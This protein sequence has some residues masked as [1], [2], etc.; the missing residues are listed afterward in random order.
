[1]PSC[2]CITATPLNNHQELEF[3]ADA[4]VI[5]PRQLSTMLSQLPADLDSESQE[6]RSL[7]RQHQPS[8]LQ[9]V[10]PAPI[11]AP[12]QAQPP[13]AA[14]SPP[15]PAATPS[16]NE[17]AALHNQYASP[18]PQAPPAYPQVPPILS[19]AS[20]LYA[21]TPTDQGDLALQPND[22]VQ[23]IEHM[24]DDCML[25]RI[26]R[27]NAPTDRYFQGGVVATSVPVRKVSSLEATSMSLMRR[28][29]S[30]RRRRL[31]TTGTCP[32]TSVRAVRAPLLPMTRS[33]RISLSRAVRNLA[34]S[35][36]MLVSPPNYALL[37][38]VI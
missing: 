25:P 21:Y 5:T 34:R 11:P 4:S 17:K 10:A 38:S 7:P 23:V 13:P 33:R 18:P 1:M 36:A 28:A 22:R 3:L 32:W 37:D 12:V 26:R 20:A 14:Y 31:A 2:V 6:T 15:A 35:L 16:Y 29:G 30:P 24:N 9:V 27:G 8:P 19:L